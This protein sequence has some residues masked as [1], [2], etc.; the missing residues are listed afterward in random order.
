MYGKKER[1]QAKQSRG[2]HRSKRRTSATTRR[3]ARASVAAGRRCRWRRGKLR[4]AASHTAVTHLWTEKS[5]ATFAWC[6]NLPY[7]GKTSV[8]ATVGG[9]GMM[10]T[11]K[12]KV[13]SAAITG[14]IHIR[15]AF[16]PGDTTVYC[17]C[18]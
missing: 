18:V 3:H 12:I 10:T 8:L 15:I 17:V 1:V 4:F 16:P 7:P 5:T 11:R 2:R 9:Q 14:T 6:R 13:S